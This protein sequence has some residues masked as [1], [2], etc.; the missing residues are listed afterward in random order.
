M[1]FREIIDTH[2]K[3]AEK[4]KEKIKALNLEKQKIIDE[5]NSLGTQEGNL[6]KTDVIVPTKDSNRLEELR[7]LL[8][9]ALS[10]LETLNSDRSKAADV[11]TSLYKEEYALSATFKSAQ[12]PLSVAQ[13]KIIKAQEE[14][15]DYELQQISIN[16]ALADNSNGLN[17]TAGPQLDDA[18][19]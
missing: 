13:A 8:K 4:I 9:T 1:H 16:A 5:L 19:Q 17:Q 6:R 15:S 10:T 3:K 7:L 14:V 18:K 11:V 12:G 2:Q